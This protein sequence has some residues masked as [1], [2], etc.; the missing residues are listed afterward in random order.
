MLAIVGWVETEIGGTYDLTNGCQY[1]PHMKKMTTCYD[2][3]GKRM[4]WQKNS[5]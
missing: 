3:T 4:I 1:A 2:N 5:T